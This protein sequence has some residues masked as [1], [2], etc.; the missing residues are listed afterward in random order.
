MKMNYHQEI[1][2]WL[3]EVIIGLNLCPFAKDPF[4]KGKIK[5]EISDSKAEDKIWEDTIKEIEFLEN[6]RQLS[7]TLLALP[8]S[9]ISFHDLYDLTL[10]LEHMFESKQV[11]YQIVAFH[12][13]FKFEDTNEEDRINF[14][15]RSPYPLIHILRSE[16]MNA[17]LKDESIGIKINQANE[18]TLNLLSENEFKKY[19]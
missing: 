19:F 12:P 6:N 10:N 9:Q 14:V 5:I 8:K 15:N 7:T 18:K 13:N 11:P 3:K 4:E 17:I 16:E 1:E 2:T